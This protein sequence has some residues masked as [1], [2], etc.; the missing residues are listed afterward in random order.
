[1]L[2][3][4]VYLFFDANNTRHQFIKNVDEKLMDRKIECTLHAQS[5]PK[6]LVERFKFIMANESAQYI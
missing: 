2:I 4:S 3:N 6:H 1:M 5:S